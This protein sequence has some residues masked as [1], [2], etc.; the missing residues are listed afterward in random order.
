[1]ASAIVLAG[2][3]SSRLGRD[4]AS[5]VVAGATLLQ[6]VLNRVSGLASE[7]IVVTRPGQELPSIASPPRSVEDSLPGKGPLAG[8]YTGLT[9]ATSFPAI[10]VAGDMPLLQPPLLQELLD[11]ALEF[12]AVVP[13]RQGLP[14]PLCAVYNAACIE[15][16]RS[17]IERDDLKMANFLGDVRT[18]YVG[19][20]EWQRVDPNGLSFFNLNT[21]EDLARAEALLGP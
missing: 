7:V 21:P 14:E 19:E 10:A 13:R 3:Q 18:R 17:C 9:A 12:D 2:G 1:M 5:I 11:L 4:K 16:I 15:A 20:D 6:H 8:L